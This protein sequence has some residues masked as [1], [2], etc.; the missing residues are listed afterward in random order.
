MTKAEVRSI[1]VAELLAVQEAI[2]CG[3]PVITDE[4]RPIGDLDKF[5]S[6]LAED[7]TATILRKLGAPDD[8]KSPFTMREDGKYFTLD[9]VVDHFFLA[10]GAKEAHAH[11]GR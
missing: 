11:A 10:V 6:Q 7:T 2:G 5:D 8:T 9:R 3:P 4:T 1:V